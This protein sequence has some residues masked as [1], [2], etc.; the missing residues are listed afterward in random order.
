MIDT[1]AWAFKKKP[2]IGIMRFIVSYGEYDVS[3][4]FT[5]EALEYILYQLPPLVP[6]ED[7]KA[8]EEFYDEA[9]SALKKR[10]R[11]LKI[12]KKYSLPPE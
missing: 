8:Y 2:Y 9:Y 4:D 7:D 5:D 3:K 12:F 6:A 11:F 1:D 10:P